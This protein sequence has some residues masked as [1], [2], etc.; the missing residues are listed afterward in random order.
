LCGSFEKQGRVLL[1]TSNKKKVREFSGILGFELEQFDVDLDEVQAVDPEKVAFH[2]AKKAFELSRCPVVVEDTALYFSALGG[3]PG[4]LIKWLEDTAG[5]ESA[6]RVLDG[7]S[8]RSAVA[9]SCVVFFDGSVQKMFRGRVKGMIS[10]HPCGDNGFGWD[11]IFIPK[12]ENK[13]FA[14][15][16]AVK[17]DSMSMRKKALLQLKEFFF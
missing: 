14:Q 2:K 12:N 6:C 10:M 5:L 17:K 1:A 7:F 9:E 11:S 16:S 3:F 13:S 8:D 15:M 4:A